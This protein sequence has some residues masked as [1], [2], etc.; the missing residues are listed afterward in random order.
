MASH[1]LGK[2]I[3]DIIAHTLTAHKSASLPGET[4]YK[5]KAQKAQYE[6]YEKELAPIVV[7]MLGELAKRK[8]LPEPLKTAVEA[9]TGPKHQVEILILVALVIGFITKAAGEITQPFAQSV[10]ND[11]WKV[12]QSMPLDLGTIA[13]LVVKGV[14]D[15]GQGTDEASLIGID[16]QRA[17]DV[18]AGAGEPPGPIEL[19]AAFRRGIIGENDVERGIRTGRLRNEWIPMFK[20]LTYSPPSPAEAIQAYVQGHIDESTSRK[21]SSESGL[22]P[23]AFQA[24]YETAGNPISPGEAL[25]LLRRGEMDTGS[26]EQA[27]RESRI[28]N[29]YIPAIMNLARRLIPP[30]TV[31]SMVGHGVLDMA[32]GVRYLQMYGYTADDATAVVKNALATKHAATK[33]LAKSEIA[34]A[35]ENQM[36]SRQ[37]AETSL[38]KLGYDHGEAT[39]LLDIADHKRQEAIRSSAI[40][41]IGS[42]YIARHIS[43]GTAS[44]SLDALQVPTDA[45]DSILALW[46][47]ELSASP[48]MLTLAEIGALA[49]KSLMSPQVFHDK[50]TALGYSE[51]DTGWLALY[52]GAVKPSA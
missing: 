47:L 23:G 27:I 22:D 31:S 29:K 52:Y 8:D 14:L 21:W 45:R 33:E 12:H 25:D 3:S 18:F 30:R 36:M 16:T 49:K 46:D 48:K 4:A 24:L 38:T 28:K 5:H 9:A 39:L 19:L 6:A 11:M 44:T 37:D 2:A 20:G 10:I 26:V 13:E 43:R 42:R 7:K 40:R 15:P 34:M 1:R 50:V 32:T 17:A 35:Y 41:I 51:E